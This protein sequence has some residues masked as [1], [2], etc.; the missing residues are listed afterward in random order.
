MNFNK[1]CQIK[2]S[3]RKLVKN[4]W[5]SIKIFKVFICYSSMGLTRRR[6]YLLQWLH[7]KPKLRQNKPIPW[8]LLFLDPAI[9]PGFHQ[10]SALTT[11]QVYTG[12]R[13]VLNYSTAPYQ[14]PSYH[15]PTKPGTLKHPGLFPFILILVIRLHFSWYWDPNTM[16][17]NPTIIVCGPLLIL[18]SP[19]SISGHLYLK[20]HHHSAP[21][22][23]WAPHIRYIST[24]GYSAGIPVSG[25]R[26]SWTPPSKYF[27]F[28]SGFPCSA[29]LC[30]ELHYRSVRLWYWNPYISY[31]LEIMNLEPQ[32]HCVWP[33]FD[34]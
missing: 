14:A 23:S 16:I 13:Y 27:L 17:S 31:S 6:G 11:L 9:N 15:E 29:H 25:S 8:P 30:L 1:T 34:K 7:S 4:L 19:I 2:S 10:Y 21:P 3:C 22:W 5:W 32:H 26:Q 12:S 18:G 24:L 20:T 28:D 33:S